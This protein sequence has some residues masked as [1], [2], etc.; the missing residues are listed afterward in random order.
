MRTLFH[1]L[2]T[3]ALG[4]AACLDASAQTANQNQ[5]QTR[6]QNQNTTNQ[7]QN[8]TNQNQNNQNNQGERKVLRGVIAGVTVEGEVAIDYR[9]N[10]A[11][12]AEMTYLTIVGSES[13]RDRDRDDNAA[14]NRDQDDRDQ[15]RNRDQ[16]DR[17]DRDQARNRD[18][19]DRDR[20]NQNDNDRRAS[21]ATSGTTSM[22]SGSRRGP[23]CAGRAIATTTA[24][25]TI[26]MQTTMIAIATTKTTTDPI[27]TATP[28]GPATL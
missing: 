10:R 3:L 15:A 24:S 21:P 11:A 26:R 2:T 17:N 13:S 8:T 4:L 22:W 7:N 27:G 25:A 9:T 5:N 14:R 6:D 28:I 23:K 12:T 18:Q 20:G 16:N 1:G 19:N